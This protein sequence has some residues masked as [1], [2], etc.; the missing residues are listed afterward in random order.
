MVMFI[1]IIDRKTIMPK[2]GAERWWRGKLTISTKYG[3]EH[4]YH[5]E[6]KH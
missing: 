2:K 3:G 4:R 1:N 6:T 5:I